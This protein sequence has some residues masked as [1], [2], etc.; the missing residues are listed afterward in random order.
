MTDIHAPLELRDT[1][2]LWAINKALFRPHGIALGVYPD[3]SWTI[4]HNPVPFDE[5]TDLQ[6]QEAFAAFLKE[7]ADGL[8]GST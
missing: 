4:V 5:E 8:P 6:K 7:H 1:G 2:I 3:G